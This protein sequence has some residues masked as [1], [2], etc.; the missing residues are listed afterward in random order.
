MK[1]GFEFGSVTVYSGEKNGKYPDGNQVIVTGRSERAAF[2]SPLVAN[3]LGQ[4]FC[5]CD[6][7]IQGHVHEDH[8]TGLHLIPDRPVYVHEADIDMARSREGYQRAAGLPDDVMAAMFS[9]IE[10]H[11]FY[12]PIP[13]AIAYTDGQCWDLG[14][15]TVQAIHAPGHTR[16][17]SILYVEKEG[18]AFIGDIDLTGF[19]PYYAD[20]TS[21][22]PEFRETL[23]KLPE[24]DARAWV[25]SHHRGVYTDRARMLADL[26]AFADKIE[27][28]SATL[29]ERLRTKPHT[30]DELIAERLLYPKD[31]QPM[32]VDYAEERTI[33]AH[34]DELMASG[35]VTLT[36]GFYTA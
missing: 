33:R 16:G 17:H 9:E 28:R 14:G 6:L 12:Q 34:L 31:F 20:A 32:W 11:F 23:A 8:T 1:A 30:L 5:S 22:L 35:E 15:V 18:V 4:I 13:D 10:A 21:S 24:L 26:A 19:G 36:D 7:A 3:T 25:T 27:Q 29:R 2:D